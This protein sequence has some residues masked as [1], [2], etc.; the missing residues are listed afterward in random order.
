MAGWNLSVTYLFHQSLSKY[1][2]ETETMCTFSHFTVMEGKLNFSLFKPRWVNKQ[3][4]RRLGGEGPHTQSI[5]ESLE[6]A[7]GY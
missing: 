7:T 2:P 4:N 5:E 1:M 3:H 6:Q